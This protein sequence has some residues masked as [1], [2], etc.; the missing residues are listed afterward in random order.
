MRKFSVTF[1]Q[2]L[3]ICLRVCT[4]FH[5]KFDFSYVHHKFDD[6]T[7]V[8]EAPVTLVV[9]LAPYVYRYRY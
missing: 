4:Y 8:N 2:V 5:H 6:L 7:G 9:L 1:L 3:P